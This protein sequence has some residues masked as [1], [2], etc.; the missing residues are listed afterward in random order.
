[1]CIIK[2]IIKQIS[3]K[4]QRSVGQALLSDIIMPQVISS[5]D[6]QREEEKNASLL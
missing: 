5:R 3:F 2:K 1:M 6:I 4:K